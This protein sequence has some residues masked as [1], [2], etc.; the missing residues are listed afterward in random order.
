VFQATELDSIENSF[1]EFSLVYD[2]VRNTH[3]PM[4]GTSN[5]AY[6]LAMEKPE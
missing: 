3:Y 1:H 5:I 4:Q 6:S 2:Y